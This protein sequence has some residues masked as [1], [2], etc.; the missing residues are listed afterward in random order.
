MADKTILVVEDMPV[1][2]RGLV[3]L[4]K[5]AGY[6]VALA[7]TA[8]EAKGLLDTCTGIWLVILDYH[9]QDG[10]VGTEILDALRDKHGPNFAAPRVMTF[11]GREDGNLMMMEAAAHV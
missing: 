11:S 7:V 1:T 2:A 9:L 5:E 3:S 8:A 6:E 4:L 10:S